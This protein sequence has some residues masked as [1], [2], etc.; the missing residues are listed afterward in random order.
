MPGFSSTAVARSDLRRSIS[1]RGEV[2]VL[3]PQVHLVERH[4]LSTPPGYDE[5]LAARELA[6]LVG[7]DARE[8][9]FAGRVSR[10]LDLL[11]EQ[12]RA[13]HTRLMGGLGNRSHL[14]PHGAGARRERFWVGYRMDD[15]SASSRVEDALGVATEA[16]VALSGQNDTGAELAGALNHVGGIRTGRDGGKLVEHHQHRPVGGFA[17]GEVVGEVLEEEASESDRLGRQ[18]ESL[19]LD[20]ARVAVLE[21]PC[22]VKR[23]FE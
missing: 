7:I 23:A 14:S 18:A 5:G 3:V 22:S 17:V 21:R 1:A 11:I 2:D 20:V 6:D 12:D 16:G 13:H 15:E 4:P 9:L 10:R 8:L 19:E